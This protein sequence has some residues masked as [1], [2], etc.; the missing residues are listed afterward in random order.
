MAGL[1]LDT[2]QMQTAGAGEKTFTR[3]PHDT[4]RSHPSCIGVIGFPTT[5][6]AADVS[7]R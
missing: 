7:G 6:G 5:D 4:L 2:P 3:H 1:G